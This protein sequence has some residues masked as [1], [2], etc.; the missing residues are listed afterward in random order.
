LTDLSFLSEELG[1]IP[2]GVV[3]GIWKNLGQMMD[4]LR[5][6]QGQDWLTACALRIYAPAD[7]QVRWRR[8]F[9]QKLGFS[10][11]PATPEESRVADS[12]STEIEHGQACSAHEIRIFLKKQGWTQRELAAE[13][14]KLTKTK[15]SL[16]RVERN[17][18][19]NGPTAKFLKVFA[20]VKAH[21]P[22]PPPPPSH[23]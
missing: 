12:R 9:S 15:C 21:T 1:L 7:W 22:S 4:C 5:N 18:G 20:L 14:E 3:N 8:Y 19:P 10:W 13:I 2:V 16:R 17:L 11:I 6:G 23:D